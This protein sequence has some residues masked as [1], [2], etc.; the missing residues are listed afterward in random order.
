MNFSTLKCIREYSQRHILCYLSGFLCYTLFA[1]SISEVTPFMTKLELMCIEDSK[2]Q[3]CLIK[4]CNVVCF[5]ERQGKCLSSRMSTPC[6]ASVA[7]QL[8]DF[9]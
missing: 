1:E 6:I 3:R 8:V 4:K 9:T 5:S 2:L 7:L